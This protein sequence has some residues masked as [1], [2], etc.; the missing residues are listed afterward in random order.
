V[1]T[2]FSFGSANGYEIQVLTKSSGI[3]QC[4]NH[5]IGIHTFTFLEINIM[6]P[7]PLISAIQLKEI[8]TQ[9]KIVL[10]DATMAP[11]G[12]GQELIAEFIPGSIRF[13]FDHEIC[14]QHSDL[15]HMLPTPAQFAHQVSALGVSNDS[16][17][18]I[19]DRVGMFAAPRAW[20]M[21]RVMGHENVQ[22]LD[23][24]LAAWKQ[25]GY[26]VAENLDKPGHSGYFNATFQSHLS[27]GREDVKV[28]L[29]DKKTGVLDARS[30]GRFSGN[31][32]EPRPNLLCGHMPGAF[33]IPFTQVLNEGRMKSRNELEAVFSKHEGKR[34]LFSCGSGVTACILALGAEIAGFTN[35]AVYD[36][37]WAEW[38]RVGSNLPVISE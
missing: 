15:P 24:G 35:W 34:L 27:V 18:V 21:F 33:N 11:I 1:Q 14:D 26:E 17:V 38:G 29:N 37:S 20:W 3:P 32:P 5:H 28:A 25:A 6:K 30:A 8:L 13:D 36:G 12:S 2:V 9:E 16:R 22:V 23:G 7:T 4:K 31:E 10:L 19:Y